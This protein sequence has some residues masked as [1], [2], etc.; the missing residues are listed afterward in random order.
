MKKPVYEIIDWEAQHD[1]LS[2][3]SKNSH[4]FAI[5]LVYHWLLAGRRNKHNNQLKD[6]R[7]RSCGEVNE[8]SSHFL[9]CQHRAIEKCFKDTVG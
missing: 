2:K 8:A 5:Q 9:T 4:R 1:A 6:N 7:C 3:L